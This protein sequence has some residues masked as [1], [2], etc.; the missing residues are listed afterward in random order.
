MRYHIDYETM[1]LVNGR[2]LYQI[3][4]DEDTLTRSKGECGGWIEK[5]ENLSQ[6]GRCWV[7]PDAF[8]YGGARVYGDAHVRNSKVFSK[9]DIGGHTHVYDSTVCGS[10]TILDRACV[11]SCTVYSGIIRGNAHVSNATV[12]GFVD[13]GTGADIKSNKDYMYIIHDSQEYTIYRTKNGIVAAVH[14]VGGLPIEKAAEDF[15][16]LNHIKEVF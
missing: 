4:C 11:Q 15:P 6:D 5:E 7:Y 2:T 13:I 8:V 9:A 12:F 1:R 3:V 10:A 14:G 16:W